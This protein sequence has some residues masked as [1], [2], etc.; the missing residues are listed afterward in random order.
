MQRSYYRFDSHLDFNKI[1]SKDVM[2]YI[3]W[4]WNNK[5]SLKA[6]IEVQILLG[7]LM[8]K[9]S[10][11]TRNALEMIF[12]HGPFL[13]NQKNHIEWTFIDP[14]HYSQFSIIELLIVDFYRTFHYWTILQ[15]FTKQYTQIS[16][17]LIT[18][19]CYDYELKFPIITFKKKLWMWFLILKTWSSS[20]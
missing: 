13:K 10:C 2:V 20:V 3:F 8:L 12:L 9:D 19:H 1:C 5:I 17:V 7:N 4:T 14:L 16:Y 15:N 6:K 18:W 11:Q